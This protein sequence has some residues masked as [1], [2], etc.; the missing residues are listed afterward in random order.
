[1]D[2][3]LNAALR[4]AFK[5][6][7]QEFIDAGVHPVAT[8]EKFRGQPQNPEAFEYY[9]LPAIFVQRSVVWTR[10]G[11]V[12]NGQVQ[13]TF[14]V[15]TDPSTTA[16]GY[17]DFLDKVREVLDNFRTAFSSTMIRTADH[18]L[19]A[20]VVSYDTLGY[21]STYYGSTRID[22]VYQEETPQTMDLMGGLKTSMKEV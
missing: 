2:K 5:D 4:Q 21:E 13:W 14:H 12:Y 20:A 10:E 15:E 11:K 16:T 18:E 7:E 22:P 8:I 19:D 9:E 17:E 1:M 3:Q 6:A